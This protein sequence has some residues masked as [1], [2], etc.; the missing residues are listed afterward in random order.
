M[1]RRT[2]NIFENDYIKMLNNKSCEITM[3]NDYI[4][5]FFFF[6]YFNEKSINDKTFKALVNQYSILYAEDFQIGNKIHTLVNDGFDSLIHMQMS[7]IE[8]F[9]YLVE[10][11]L[12]DKCDTRFTKYITRVLGRYVLCS[13]KSALIL[14]NYLIELYHRDFSFEFH[15]KIKEKTRI[16]ICKYIDEHLK[17]NKYDITA[18]DMFNPVNSKTKSANKIC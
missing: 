1:L 7:Y 4:H 5:D 17:L 16:E 9:S 14:F 10:L 3:Y 6:I 8:N 12:V 2:L 13:K 18:E 15:E 11:N